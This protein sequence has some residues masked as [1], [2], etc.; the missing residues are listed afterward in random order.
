MVGLPDTEDELE[1]PIAEALRALPDGIFEEDGEAT[2]RDGLNAADGP[3]MVLPSG[4]ARFTIKPSGEPQTKGTRYYATDNVTG[5]TFTVGKVTTYGTRR[6]LSYI[7][8]AVKYDRHAAESLHGPWAHFMW[9]TVMAESNGN[10]LSINA[11]DRAHFTWGFYQLAAHTP[12]DNFVLLL[13]KLLGLSD[14]GDYFPDLE[15]SDGKVHQRTGSGLIDLEAESVVTVGSGTETQIRRLMTYLNPDSKR[16]D[17]GEA[18]TV[19]RMLA[20]A[21][22]NPEVLLATTAVSIA[23]MKAKLKRLDTRFG[24]SGRR[25][26]LAIWVSDMYHHGRGS[27]SQ[28]REAL[29]KPTFKS[30]LDALSKIDS[31][32]VHGNRLKAVKDRVAEL[33]DEGRFDGLLFGKGDLKP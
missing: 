15:L 16:M 24:L 32:G 14:A 8:G 23:I 7:S 19:A 5:V 18:V 30:Q 17:E 27:T 10:L 1:I 20:W 12:K 4:S 6:G 21:Q 31:T 3:P 28:V 33:M 13:R 29:K 25:P 2:Y 26:E 22:T 9:P 11:W